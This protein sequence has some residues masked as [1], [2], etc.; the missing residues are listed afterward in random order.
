MWQ[1]TKRKQIPEWIAR[2]RS[3]LAELRAADPTLRMFGTFM[4]QY[5][6]GPPLAQSEITAAETHYQISISPEYR[7]FL[8]HIGNGGAGPGYGLQRFGVLTTPV[9]RRNP[10]PT[11]VMDRDGGVGPINEFAD[12]FDE[13]YF[14]EME[15]L[16]N[17]RSPLARP[18]PLTRPWTLN[19]RDIPDDD[20]AYFQWDI[21]VREPMF[22]HGSV[23]LSD[24]G[25][26][27]KHKLVVT[28]DE[29][30]SVWVFDEQDG[31]YISPYGAGMLPD[32]AIP[33]RYTFAEWYE[34]WLI[35][36]LHNARN[37]T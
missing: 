12:C 6:L 33:R 9:I 31:E 27:Q 8:L 24:Q 11:V 13:L 25:C 32:D 3:R 17:D 2:V 14:N 4:H 16:I 18:F 23:E 36:Y 37:A 1:R 21:N 20:Y 28:G 15:R 7:D 34:D 29:S 5:R 10:A 30:G 19:D 26:G 35:D 22:K